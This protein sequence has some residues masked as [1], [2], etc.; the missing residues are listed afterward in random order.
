MNT[1]SNT[2][3]NIAEIFNNIK[4]IVI[5]YA[6]KFY[7]DLASLIGEVP[8]KMTIMIVVISLILFIALKIINR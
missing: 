4:N 3:A 6:T 8:A 1:W 7:E 5:N 2:E